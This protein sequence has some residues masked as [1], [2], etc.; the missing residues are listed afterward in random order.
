MQSA[1]GVPLQSDAFVLLQVPWQRQSTIA[2]VNN[3]FI[4]DLKVHFLF[5]A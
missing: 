5:I 2:A 4:I 3:L 1:T